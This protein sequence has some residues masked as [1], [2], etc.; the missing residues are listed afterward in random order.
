MKP[1]PASHCRKTRRPLPTA[2]FT[3]LELALALAVFAMVMTS[4][5]ACWSSIL[6]SARVGNEA[7]AEAQRARVASRTLETALNSAVMFMA[8]HSLYRFE[9]DTSGEFAALSFLARLPA[10]FPGGGYYGDQVVRRVAFVVEPGEGSLNE[11]RL[12]QFPILSGEVSDEQ[13][14]PLTIAQDVSLFMLEFSD[15][16]SGEWMD[17]WTMTN[18]L[19]A[20]V[21]FALAFGRKNDGSNTPR[22]MVVHSVLLPTRGVLPTFQGMAGAAGAMGRGQ[23]GAP[24]VPGPDAGGPATGLEDIRPEGGAG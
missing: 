16:K 22:E 7:A 9:A 20:M 14:H 18:R 5:Y 8:N 21:R 13:L 15:G 12:I 3:L 2:A 19:P 4:I 24:I 1:G 11:L 6:R 10:S 23:P 17:E